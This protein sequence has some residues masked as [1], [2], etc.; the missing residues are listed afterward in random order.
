MAELAAGKRVAACVAAAGEVTGRVAV[1][2][3][4]VAA[5]MGLAVLWA[6]ATKH[7]GSRVGVSRVGRRADRPAAAAEAA[8]G[9]VMLAVVVMAVTTLG[10]GLTARVVARGVEVVVLEP[11]RRAVARMATVTAVESVVATRAE[12]A[13]IQGHRGDWSNVEPP[14]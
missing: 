10:V 13:G 1:A 11:V 6:A 5:A 9:L 3:V 8:M 4:V 14:A 7:W 12:A 2:V